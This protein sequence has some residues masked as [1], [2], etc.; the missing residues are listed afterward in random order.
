MRRLRSGLVVSIALLTA[1]S[2][3]DDV[4]DGSTSSPTTVATEP[5]ITLPQ[6]ST[7][8]TPTTES[9]PDVTAP[10][11]RQDLHDELVTMFEQDQYYR[12]GAVPAGKP[13]PEFV[14]DWVR[15]NRLQQIIDEVGWPTFDL[16]GEEGAT[17]AWIIAQHADLN[18]AFQERARDLLQE[19][20]ADGQGDPVELAYLDDRVRVNEGLDQI[21]GT[22]VRCR[23]GEPTPATPIADP[24]AVDGMR[25]ELGL[26]AL[27]V[28]YEEFSLPCRDEA[29][30]GVELG[31]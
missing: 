20:V 26:P 27:E 10:A 21:Y 8:A 9:E 30:D 23:D 25:S 2:G 13:T 28:Y 14:E 24:E 5:A 19:A 17:G 3:T 15:I 31:G 18:P 12:T 22:Q 1:C 6:A 16:V 7:T 29:A 11:F 4:A